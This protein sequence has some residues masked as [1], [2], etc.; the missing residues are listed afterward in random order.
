MLTLSSLLTRLSPFIPQFADS[1]GLPTDEGLFG[2]KPFSEMWCG[3]LAM[4]GF[5][6]SIVE[7][8]MTGRG[9]LQ[10]LGLN[11]PSESLFTVLLGLLALG[12]IGGTASTAVKLATRKMSPGDVARYKNFLGLNNADDWKI[13]EKQMKGRPD[14]ATPNIDTAAIAQTRAEGMPADKVLSLQDREAANAAAR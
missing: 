9:T 2:F 6:T 3:R 14:F 5:V 12:L 11:T 1:I 10:Q 8:A 7:E 13:A 4:M